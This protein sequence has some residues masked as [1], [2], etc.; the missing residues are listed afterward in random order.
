[1]MMMVMGTTNQHAMT[2]IRKRKE[3]KGHRIQLNPGSLCFLPSLSQ[4]H[5]YMPKCHSCRRVRSLRNV[6]IYMY[7]YSMEI[8]YAGYLVNPKKLKRR[9]K[10][11]GIN[12]NKKKQG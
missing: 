11:R 6:Y 8:K 12:R 2:Y 3:N 5:E 4:R 1:M 7:V 9:G 10:K